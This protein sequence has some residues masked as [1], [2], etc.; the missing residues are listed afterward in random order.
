MD[1]TEKILDDLVKSLKLSDTNKILATATEN[2]IIT[3]VKIDAI[4]KTLARII[5]RLDDKD[6]KEIEIEI[7]KDFMT[8]I[9][10]RLNEDYIIKQIYPKGI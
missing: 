6:Y 9:N 4:I 7:R 10:E 1:E 5:A 3:N 8:E 2:Y